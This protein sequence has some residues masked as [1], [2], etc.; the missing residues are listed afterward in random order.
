[1]AV[2]LV[3]S[4]AILLRQPAILPKGRP[5]SS[6]QPELQTTSSACAISPTSRSGLVLLRQ[7]PTLVAI[8]TV[9]VIVNLC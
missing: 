8:L 1:L 2:L 7:A 9:T 6:T 4:S 5:A 3:G